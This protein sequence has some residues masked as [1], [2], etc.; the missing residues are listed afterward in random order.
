MARDCG[1]EAA[2]VLLRASAATFRTECTAISQ[3]RQTDRQTDPPPQQCFGR[4]YLPFAWNHLEVDQFRR[5]ER[6]KKVLASLIRD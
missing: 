6:K 3:L 1:L 4:V 5:R 2:A